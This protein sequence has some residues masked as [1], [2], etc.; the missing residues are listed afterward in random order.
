MRQIRSD[1]GT[2]FVGAK[3]EF[4]KSLSELDKDRISIYLAKNQCDFQ[5]NVPD[6]S[7]RGGVWERVL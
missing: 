2:N 4:E 6:A 7:H 5:M 3:N 1:Q